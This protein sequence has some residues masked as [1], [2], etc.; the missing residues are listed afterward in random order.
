[1]I[2]N[3]AKITIEFAKKI[4]VLFNNYK[5][6][7]FFNSHFV[8]VNIKIQNKRIRYFGVFGIA[9]NIFFRFFI[10]SV[11]AVIKVL[12]FDFKP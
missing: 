6:E 9:K 7:R 12:N 8:I 1:M 11:I 3:N 10:A 5:Y 2:K 4:F